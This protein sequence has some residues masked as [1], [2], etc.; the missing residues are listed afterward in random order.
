MESDVDREKVESDIRYR[1][2][3][4]FRDA[5]ITIAF[6]QRDVHLDSLSPIEV[7]MVPNG[8]D[9]ESPDPDDLKEKLLEKHADKLRDK[10]GS[11]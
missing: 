8:S 6:P 11:D 2:D 5:G 4:L 10:T 1:I 7:K 3:S 9:S